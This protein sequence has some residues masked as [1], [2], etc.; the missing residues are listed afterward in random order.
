[1]KEEALTSLARY[2]YQLE[3]QIKAQKDFLSSLVP[4]SIDAHHSNIVNKMLKCSQAAGVGPMAGVAGAIAE[5]VG[6]DLSKLST[7]VIVENGGDIFIKS[8]QSVKI[9][10]FAGSSPLNNK[11]SL[12]ITPETTPIGVCTSSGKIG[13]SLSFGNADAVCIVSGSATLADCAATAVANMIA[14]T[15]DADI[16]H[17][18]EVAKGIEGVRGCVIISGVKMGCWGDIQIC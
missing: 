14:S 3:R 12:L 4:I 17:A 15:T 11:I 16:K 7:N 8:Q 5:F 1:M 13:N 9:G 10:I 2:R 6:G 18:L